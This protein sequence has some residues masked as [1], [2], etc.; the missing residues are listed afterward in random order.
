MSKLEVDAIE[1]QSGTTLTIGASGDSVNIA[2]GA[3]ITDFTST[4][5]DDNATSTA[6][7]IDSSENVGIGTASPSRPLTVAGTGSTSGGVVVID[8]AGAIGLEIQSNDPT[9]LFYEDDT[10]DQNYQIRLQSG[11]LTFQTQNDSR[12]SATERMRITSDGRVGIGTATPSANLAVVDSRNAG[13]TEPHFR[14]NGSGYSGFHFLDGT[15]YY[16][17][18]NSNSRRIRIYSGANENAGAQLSQGATSFSTYSDERLKKDITDLT[19]G[20]DKISGIRAVKFKYKTDADDYK[21]RIGVIAQSLVGQVDEALDLSRLNDTDTTEY[22]DVRYQDLIPV[23]VKA[24]QEAK[25]KIET[26]ETQR[27]DLEAR[28]IALENA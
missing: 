27:A 19:N 15:A 3:T 6:I 20:L 10:T 25:T 12:N 22:Y 16:I 24:L 13:E 14:I 11:A 8:D 28:I 7:T 9:L 26:L 1:P 4:G 17:G 18:Q 5:I 21:T 23:L 2:S